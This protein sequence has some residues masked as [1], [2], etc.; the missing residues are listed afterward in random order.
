[1]AYTEDNPMKLGDNPVFSLKTSVITLRII[2]GLYFFLSIVAGIYIFVNLGFTKSSVYYGIPINNEANPL[3]I[4]IGSFIIIQGFILWII[5]IVIAGTSEA[6]MRIE[7]KIFSESN[8][9]LEG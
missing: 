6:V 3:Y 9:K 2:A 1:M 7:E 8:A 4:G 5:M